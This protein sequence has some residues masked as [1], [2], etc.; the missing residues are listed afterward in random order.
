MTGYLSFSNGN[1]RVIVQ[2]MPICKD[3]PPDFALRAAA[4]LRVT[5]QPEAWN[6]D[7]GEWVTLSTIEELQ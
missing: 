2:G 7:R 1:Y 5:L 6:G 3:G 4:S